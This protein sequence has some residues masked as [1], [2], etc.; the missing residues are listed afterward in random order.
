MAFENRSGGN[1]RGCICEIEL[2]DITVKY[3][4]KTNHRAGAQESDTHED[5]DL[6]EMFAY[7]LLEKLGV[8]PEI[9][10]IADELDSRWILYIASR[11]IPDF[12]TI[13]QIEWEEDNLRKYVIPVAQ[14][15]ALYT[16]LDMING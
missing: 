6:K 15:L 16:I 14:M 4:I 10:F 1:R 8:G 11:D 9:H 12:K 2:E 13:K 7:K 5:L 3:H